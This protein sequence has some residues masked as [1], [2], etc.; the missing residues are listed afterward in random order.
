MNILKILPPLVDFG[1]IALIGIKTLNT[2]CFNPIDIN[3]SLSALIFSIITEIYLL[4]KYQRKNET[5]KIN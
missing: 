5:E 3:L 1:V 4:N 2:Q